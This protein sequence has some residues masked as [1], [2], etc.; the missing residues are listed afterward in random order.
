MSVTIQLP[1]A[2]RTFT[3]GLSE[4]VV[5]AATIDE[6]LRQLTKNYADLKRH[7]FDDEE[8]L[9]SFVNVYLNDEDIRSLNG[10]ASDVKSGDTIMLIPAIAGGVQ[11]K[12][13][14]KN[15]RY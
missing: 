1:T 4:V 13:R 11:H 10:T 5:E 15:F 7:L 14:H 3:D 12:I 8:K 9:R 6:A 2:L